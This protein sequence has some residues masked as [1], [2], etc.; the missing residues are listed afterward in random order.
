MAGAEAGGEMVAFEEAMGMRSS[1]WKSV[2]FMSQNDGSCFNDRPSSCKMVS[3]QTSIEECL[4]FHV[5][6][7]SEFCLLVF[8]CPNACHPWPRSGEGQVE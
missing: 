1:T 5:G 4:R 2:R 6:L 3:F 8:V 7:F